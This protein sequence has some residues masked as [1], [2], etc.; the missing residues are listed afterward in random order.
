M[1]DY[2]IGSLIIM[3]TDFGTP[4]VGYGAWVVTSKYEIMHDADN[5]ILID[6]IGN[7]KAW[8]KNKNLDT[9]KCR[10]SFYDRCIDERTH[11]YT[12]MLGAICGDVAGS[13]Y[14]HHNIKYVPDTAHLI[15][16]RARITDDSVM[17]LAVA[18]GIKNSMTALGKTRN[19][20]NADDSAFL[21]EI[22]AAVRKW[23]MQYP[24]AG[25]GGAFRKWLMQP[26]AGPYGSM[27]NGSAMRA[28]Y[29][30]WIASSLDDAEYLASVSARISHDHPEG[31]KGAVA[32][33]GSI[34][35]LAHHCKG[36][37]TVQ[38][39]KEMVR[40]YVSRFYDLNFTLAEIRSDY[41]FDVTCPGSVPV[42]VK[43]FLEGD[44][45]S[46]VLALAI[47]VGGDSDT[48]AAMAGSL[49]ETIFPISEGI[50]D[51]V[52]KRMDYSFKSE[53]AG[54]IDFMIDTFLC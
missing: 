21:R 14:E 36:K 26:G 13:V 4:S 53:L 27:G 19:F 52:L 7:A 3:P 38:E 31:I 2:S 6:D 33:A 54:T 12:Y 10:N 5:N 43:A 49:A 40:N 23:G 50:R 25:Y 35:L 8:V 17:T 15:R 22:S 9:A 29:A 1:F 46:K 48:I 45:F 41:K 32:I 28:S 18:V 16:H 11:S 47:S 20:S 34:Y 51:R 42:A 39:S 24:D 44:R 30:G 37:K